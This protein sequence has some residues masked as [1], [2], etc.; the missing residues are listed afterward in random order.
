MARLRG[1]STDR[2]GADFSASIVPVGPWRFLTD[3]PSAFD[4]LDN[5]RIAECRNQPTI[6]SQISPDNRTHFGSSQ[7]R[8]I[9]A[10]LP[11]RIMNS[12]KIAW[13]EKSGGNG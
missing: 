9:A 3:D 4:K 8:L 6:R 1:R 11:F 7:Q 2:L 12:F 10:R 13:S 5:G